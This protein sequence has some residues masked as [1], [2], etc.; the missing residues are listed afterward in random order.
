MTESSHIDVCPTVLLVDDDPDQHILVEEGLLGTNHRLL[1]ALSLAEAQLQIKKIKEI[2]LILLDLNLTD[3]KGKDT[4]LQIKKECPHIPIIVMT[5]LSDI[6]IEKELLAS[7]AQDY[8]VKGSFQYDFI[9]ITIEK[10]L[11]RYKQYQ[12]LQSSN[13][14]LAYLI[15]SIRSGQTED[16]L[17][18]ES[19]S[20]L[21]KLL[22]ST[23]FEKMLKQLKAQRDELRYLADYDFLTGIF[24]RKSFEEALKETIKKASR[25]KSIFA[26]INIDVDYFKNINDKHGHLTGDEYLK[27][28]VKMIKPI[29]RETDIF[30]RMGGDE[31]A[32][33]LTQLESASDA[34]TILNEVYEKVSEGIFIDDNYFSVKLSCGI[35]CY[36]QAG[37][38]EKELHKNS[39]LALYRAKETGRNKYFFYSEKIQLAYDRNSTLIDLVTTPFDEQFTVALQNI[40]ATNEN[41]TICAYEALLRLKHNQ[42]YLFSIEEVIATALKIHKI[43][44]LSFKL[45]ENV[46]KY[47]STSMSNDQSLF[48][49]LSVSQIFQ[50]DFIKN[51]TTLFE[52]LAI[53]CH[54]ICFEITESELIDKSVE[55]HVVPALMHLKSLGYQIAIDDFGKGYSSLSR[56]IDFPADFLKID[57]S[58]IHNITKNVKVQDITQL[59]IEVAKKINLQ[60]IA[61]GIETKEQLSILSALGVDYVQ[62]F[63]L[64]K[65]EIIG[66]STTSI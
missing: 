39:D 38:N 36:P 61:E 46:S 22:D 8:L 65:P 18:T 63:F 41:H 4:L 12:K 2:D 58:F 45:I 23:D 47:I 56:L 60:T 13:S 15:D 34:A 43:S 11:L 21:Y 29:I 40:H 7:G 27:S 33:L 6:S 66:S 9:G 20:G 32:I 16:I 31:F 17:S 44:S 62:G 50:K 24:N 28:L 19:H 30:A 37:E 25:Q 57:M 59:I 51:V 5:A 64:H 26:I 3:S 1:S 35:A 42:K 54:Q 52:Q 55:H 10:T 49:N 14:E 48:I 53:P